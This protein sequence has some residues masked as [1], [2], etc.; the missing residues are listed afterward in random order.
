MV[1]V[2]SSSHCACL[3]FYKNK[4]N[5]NDGKLCVME[6]NTSHKTIAVYN[7]ARDTEK[8]IFHL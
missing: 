3:F 6:I 8:D 5:T 2:H 7:E 4:N 1:L